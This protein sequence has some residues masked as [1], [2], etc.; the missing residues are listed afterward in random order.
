MTTNNNNNPNSPPVSE[1]TITCKIWDKEV[2][3]LVDYY[4]TKN[5]K[6]RITIN[7]SGALSREDKKVYFTPGEIKNAVSLIY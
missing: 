4:N 2:Y 5:T 7:S 3:E 6:T 1:L